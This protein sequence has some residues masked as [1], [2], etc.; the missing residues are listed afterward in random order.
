MIIATK[1][2]VYR[3]ENDGRERTPQLVLDGV[4]VRRVAEGEKRTVVATAD[5]RL[6]LLDG[7]EERRFDTGIVD[8]IDSLCVVTENPLDV[9][10]GTT[11]PHL[12][13]LGE[14]G[15]AVRIQT[16]DDLDV[17]EEWYTPWG[18]PAA[19]RSLASTQAG[20]IYADIHVGSIMR[21]PDAGRTWAPVTPSLHPDVHE[22]ATTPASESR[23]YA[24]TYRSVYVSDTQGASWHHRS[25]GLNNRYGRGIAVNPADPDTILCGVSDGPQG[26]D[27]HGQLYYTADAGVTWIHVTHGFPAST[28]KNIDT[29]HI[30]YANKDVAWVT[31]DDTLFMSGDRGQT[32]ETHWTAPEEILMISCRT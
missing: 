29:F 11:P 18:G 19:V 15:P 9:L 10:L 28:A 2:A 17:R 16:F 12:Y 31:N 32:W 27:V 8:R 21:S 7:S 14:A 25:Q 1:T 30:A 5:N 24:N 20:W 6:I 23:V 3:L 4:E 26:V 13:R 22:V